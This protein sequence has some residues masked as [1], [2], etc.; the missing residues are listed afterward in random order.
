MKTFLGIILIA[1]GVFLF[2]QGW[3]RKDSPVGAAATAGT[4]IANQVDGGAR[5]PKH[6]LT[7]VGGGALALIGLVVLFRRGSAE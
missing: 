1:F 6:V 2:V 4:E 5:I 7:M 3:Q